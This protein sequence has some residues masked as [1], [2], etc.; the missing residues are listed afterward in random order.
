MMTMRKQNDET[1]S[2][3]SED[4][5]RSAASDGDQL[6]VRRRQ[7]AMILDAPR[8][9]AKVVIERSADVYFSACRR[10][11]EFLNRGD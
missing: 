7:G 6:P 1:D 4:S 8:E 5:P 9:T 11:A 10:I 2:P 3:E